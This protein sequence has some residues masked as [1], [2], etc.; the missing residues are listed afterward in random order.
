MSFLTQLWTN[1]VAIYAAISAG[2]WAAQ[3]AGWPMPQCACWIVVGV[4][5]ALGVHAG[6][7]TIK[8]ALKVRSLDRAA[9]DLKNE[10][11][12]K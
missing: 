1:R 2:L 8:K 4:G 5:A 3:G 12:L 9:T 10:G 11:V 7:A 6:G